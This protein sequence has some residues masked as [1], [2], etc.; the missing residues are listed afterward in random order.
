MFIMDIPYVPV[1][2]TPI[3]LA[4]N[5][6]LGAS[7]VPQQPD[8]ILNACTET[9]LTLDPR[10]ALR[11]VDPAFMLKNYLEHHHKTKT[12][13][14]DLAS[15]KV[16]LIEGPKHGALVVGTSNYGRSTYRFDAEQNY[17]GNDKSIFMAEDRKSV[18]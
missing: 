2:E 3:V 10:S 5:S 14:V 16:T 17:I 18:V 15:I 8:Y 7:S 13:V 6:A 9:E 4:Q 1:Q 11:S 12:L